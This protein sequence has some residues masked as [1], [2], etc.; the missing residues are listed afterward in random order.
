MERK[1]ESKRKII[2]D[3]LMIIPEEDRKYINELHLSSA[4]LFNIFGIVAK[5][6]LG[7]EIT[8]YHFDP[9]KCQT[10]IYLK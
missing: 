5:S 1:N 4:D 9:E 2:M 8:G 7:I 10:T 3:G 6:F